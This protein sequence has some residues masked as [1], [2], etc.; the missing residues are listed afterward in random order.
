M[1]T[2]HKTSDGFPT[3]NQPVLVCN[4][5]WI[6]AAL[7]VYVVADESEGW[8]W[9]VLECYHNSLNDIYSYYA[10]D[11]YE[12]EYWIDLPDLPEIES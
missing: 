9:E 2:W 6:Q 1:T 10:D 5:K 3:H 11:G 4:D 12:F 8:I 7:A